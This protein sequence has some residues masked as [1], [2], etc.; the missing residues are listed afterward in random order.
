MTGGTVDLWGLHEQGWWATIPTNL[1][2][3]RDGTAVM[4]AGLA[5]AAADRF[6]GLDAA[7]GRSLQAGRHRVAYP[8]WRLLLVPTKRH[9]R[10]PADPTLLAESISRL[11]AWLDAHPDER[12]VVPA[13][14]CG[15]GGLDWPAVEAQLLDELA[16]QLDRVRL[17]PPR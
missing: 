4:G 10:D 5:R 1:Q 17:L 7:Y 14:G 9:W 13:L 11:R 15:L 2:T 8:A 3:R 6:D 16:G 12:L